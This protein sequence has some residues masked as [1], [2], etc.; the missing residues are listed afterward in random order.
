MRRGRVSAERAGW[1]GRGR[2]REGRQEG[3]E[4][5]V[6]WQEGE[7]KGVRVGRRRQR[8]G[9]SGSGWEMA[10]EREGEGSDC[11]GSERGGRG[12]GW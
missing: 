5:Y 6:R 10:G 9:E 1:R 3:A 2:R 7:G 8:N 11:E 4:G 12:D